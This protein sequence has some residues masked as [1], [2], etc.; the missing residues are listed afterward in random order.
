MVPSIKPKHSL[1]P[2]DATD[3]QGTGNADLHLT[4]YEDHVS[5]E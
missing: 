3:W 4:L 1:Q 2:E 5:Y